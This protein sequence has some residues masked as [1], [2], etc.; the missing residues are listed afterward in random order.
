MPRQTFATRQFFV[1]ACERATRQYIDDLP[2]LYPRLRFVSENA[3][4]H[5][6]LFSYAPEGEQLPIQISLS[7]LPLNDDCTKVT[8]HGSFANG[9]AFYNNPYMTN[10]MQNVEAALQA[11]VNGNAVFEPQQPKKKM[12][13][14]YRHARHSAA[15]FLNSVLRT[16]S[17]S[18]PSHS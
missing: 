1:N 6:L 2:G 8:V 4:L 9:C 13:H 7:T 10:A 18:R 11:A 12:A 16:R 5:C 15:A 17:L 14:R 3:K